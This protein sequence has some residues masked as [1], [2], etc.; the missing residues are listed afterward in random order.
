MIRHALS[1]VIAFGLN[2]FITTSSSAAVL[3]TGGATIDF[4]AA[5]WA[6][7][8]GGANVPGFEF[9]VPDEFFNQSAANARTSAQ[10][11]GDEI[12]ASPSFTGLTF[13]LN[14]STVSNLSGRTAQ[15]TTFSFDPSGSLTTHSGVIGLGGVTRWAINPLIGGKLV[16]GDFTLFYDPSRLAAPFNGTGWALANNVA[17][18]GVAFDIKNVVATISPGSI[19]IVGDLN[20]S[21]EVANLLFSTPADQGKDVGNI[22]FT[23]TYVPEPG[24]SLLILGAVG[25]LARR[26]RSATRLIDI[27][28]I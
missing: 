26:K 11:L 13:G 12:I 15:A 14:D 8:S 28:E 19:S 25:L 23:A 24:S 6:G 22:N 17:P 18:A 7:L 5:A 16:A 27:K 3:S 10:I 2:A 9:V 1:L 21:Y 4:D 20:I